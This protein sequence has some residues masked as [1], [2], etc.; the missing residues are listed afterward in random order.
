MYYRFF[1]NSQVIICFCRHMYLC[2]HIPALL[3]LFIVPRVMPRAA[4]PALDHQHSLNNQSSTVV[5]NHH[6]KE[7]PTAL[8][9]NGVCKN[10]HD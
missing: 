3:A 8:A 5:N 9:T 6:N 7:P 4:K 10:H 1:V 2:L